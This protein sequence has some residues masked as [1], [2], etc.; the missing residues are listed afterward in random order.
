MKQIRLATEHD[1]EEIFQLYRSLVGTPGCSWDEDYPALEDIESD[2]AQHAL[3]VLCSTEE[4]TDS[5]KILAA[6]AAGREADLETVTCW[7]KDIQ[8]PCGLSRLGVRREFQNQGLATELVRAMEQ[9]A[10]RRGFDGIHFFVSQTNPAALAVYQRL[11][12]HS[13]GETAMFG[14]NWWCYEKALPEKNGEK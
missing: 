13:C 14:I 5:P 2:L 7:S 8:H 6:V 12:Y 10:L 4:K 1:K 3:Y 11:G 9:E